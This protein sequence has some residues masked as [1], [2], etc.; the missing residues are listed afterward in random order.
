[1]T[2][3]TGALSGSKRQPDPQFHAIQ[4][5]RLP[6]VVENR[7]EDVVT[8]QR[9]LRVAIWCAVSSLVQATADKVSLIEQEQQGR[10]FAEAI[11]GVVS[12]VFTV[13]G[14]TRDLVFW[15]DAEATMP[16]YRDLREAVEAHAF[17][18]LH[19]VDVDRLGRDPALAEQVL[20][21]VER[22]GAEVYLASAPHPIGQKSIS[23]R[24]VTAI[25]AV[26]AGEDQ[27]LRLQRTR[28]GIQHRVRRGLPGTKWPYGYAPIRDSLGR[29]I[30]AEF[31][32]D[33]GAVRL[34]TDMFLRGESYRAIAARLSESPWQPPRSKRWSHAHVRMVLAC[35]TYAGFVSWGKFSRAEQSTR[36]PALWDA[37]T[38]HA[39]QAERAARAAHSRRRGVP[40]PLNGVAFCLRCGRPMN[41]HFASWPSE[42][43]CLR[44]STHSRSKDLGESCH[45]NS[46]REAKVIE[47]VREYL[48]GITDPERLEAEL[49]NLSPAADLAEQMADAERRVQDVEERRTRLALA[50][51]A[52]TVAPDVYRSAD[53][54]LE[55]NLSRAQGH[56]AELKRL[57]EAQP[58]REE[59]A[60]SLRSVLDRLDT[61]F[62]L[63]T[64]ET[65][66]VLRQAGVRVW[67]E[68]GRV[69]RVELV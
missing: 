11:G 3:K 68:E 16:A 26:R 58:S 1:M 27:A 15:S 62:T 41:R 43:R 31:D 50:L 33:I 5:C 4:V 37:E 51:A 40:S 19:A 61:L 45:L 28:R 17:D 12:H 32:D 60:Q 67:I 66:S 59:R 14:H 6:S 47:A 65:A 34:A 30:A 2:E 69:R 54:E 57:R 48:E 21:L 36:F 8:N 22:S 42:T 10:A 20:S 7:K 18:V 24:Y 53:A 63:P 44:C 39:V 52:G 9:P 13:P 49:A 64:G 56:L 35:D 25:Q 46:I 38:F 23:H 29:S 55:D